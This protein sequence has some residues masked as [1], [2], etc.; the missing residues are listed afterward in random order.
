MTRKRLFTVLIFIVFAGFTYS[1]TQNRRD[2]SG[3][4][5][6]YWE[7]VDRNGKLVYAGYFEDDMP[8]GEMKRYFPNGGVRVTMN[9][10]STST[11]ANAR[12]FWQSGNLAA[13]GNYVN[14]KRDSVWLFYSGQ[15]KMVAKRAEYTE[16][17][18]NGIEQKFY[19]DG[20]VAEELTWKEGMKNGVWKQFFRNGQLKSTATYHDDRLDGVYT[21]YFSNGKIQVEGAY[22]NDLPNDEWKRFD[23]NGK[24]LS[25]IRYVAGVIDNPEEVEAAEREFFR[26]ALE[27]E[28]TIPEPTIEDMMFGIP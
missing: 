14:T 11:K 12:F 9:Y 27:M 7:V 24:L 5:Q 28:G 2:A 25:T 15:T 20:R 1:Q 26:K 3:R 21:A 4:K 10:D 23:E 17:K 18:L 16:G 22:R 13:S 6:G 19:P 8:V